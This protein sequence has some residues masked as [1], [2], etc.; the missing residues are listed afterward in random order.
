MLLPPLDASPQFQ[1]GSGE[2]SSKPFPPGF[3]LVA[4]LIAATNVR[5]AAVVSADGHVTTAGIAV[6]SVPTMP[7]PPIAVSITTNACGA[8]AELAARKHNR[9]IGSAHGVWE[10]SRSLLNIEK[11]SLPRLM[12]SGVGL[13]SKDAV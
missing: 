5:H 10:M 13:A 11:R 3:I 4:R 9:L 12:L 8:D 1:Q 2:S 7:V 6:V